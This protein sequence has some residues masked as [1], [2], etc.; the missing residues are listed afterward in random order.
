MASLESTATAP[1]TK[2]LLRSKGG[3]HLMHG[4]RGDKNMSD[5]DAVAS[6]ALD[7]SVAA[8]QGSIA[9]FSPDGTRLARTGGSIAG[10]EIVA[11]E[12][13]DPAAAAP[14]VITGVSSGRVQKMAWSPRGTYLVTWQKFEIP[15]NFP[16]V[17][18]ELL[19]AVPGTFDE[20]S[21]GA[22]AFEGGAEGAK[23]PKI[24]N[25]R[26]WEAATGQLV[27]AFPMK[28]M[29][30]MTWPAL[31]W[32]ADEA[33]CMRMVTNEIH[34]YRGG[35]GGAEGQQQQQPGGGLADGFLDKIQLRGVAAF[36]LSPSPKLPVNVALFVPEAKA[37]P[38]SVKLYSFP[39]PEGR[40][41]V[42][43]SSLLAIV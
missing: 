12:A 10:V 29:S 43:V 3:M 36:A 11:T 31:Q 4:P 8:A 18:K 15:V 26:V 20:G 38:A 32:T 13:D 23:Q 22:S 21:A 24:G 35:G 25:L 9:E 28:K 40:P 41:P 7:G 42:A 34:I 14:V 19:N 39:G 33:W 37:A 1:G 27:E 5:A 6:L 2:L 16:N 17:P 30:A